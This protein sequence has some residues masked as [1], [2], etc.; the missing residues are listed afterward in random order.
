MTA[1]TW[2]NQPTMYISTCIMKAELTRYYL[3]FMYC[4]LINTL[5]LHAYNCFAAYISGWFYH[6][7]SK[8]RMTEPQ[9]APPPSQ[10]PGLNS[11]LDQPAEEPKKMW[12]RD[13]DS[14]YIKMAKM[15]G[16]PDLLSY[17][18][19]KPGSKEPV[20]YPRCEW[21]YHDEEP[22]IQN[23]PDKSPG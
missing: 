8:E 9:P 20:G 6:A 4:T 14:E 5:K 23:S 7:P 21:Y 19:V 22:A 3:C 12:L 17:K 16:R 2:P 15:G 18:P 1:L 13:T 11:N 10:I